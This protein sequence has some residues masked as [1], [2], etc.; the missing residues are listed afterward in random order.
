MHSLP[1]HFCCSSRFAR[2][3]KVENF[4]AKDISHP[5][6]ERTLILLSA[7][8]NFV[9]F[10]EQFCNPFVKDLRDR[11]DAMIIERDQVSR[12]LA[13][14]QQK[15]EATKW[16]FSS[17]LRPIS[18]HFDLRTKI[19]EDEPR[20]EQLRRENS[21][22]RARMF[23]TKEFQTA[24]VQEVE[25]LKAEKS[26][27]IKR[28]ASLRNNDTFFPYKRM[29]AMLTQEVLNGEITSISDAVTRSR[30]RIVQSPERIKRTISTM[31]S[32]AIEDKKIVTL[33]ETKARDLQAKINA[34]LNIEKACHFHF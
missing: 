21:A 17:R 6:R 24:A 33:H 27:L 14:V 29:T 31:S 12:E 23:A 20:C 8:I 19:A 32:T 16:A 25:K 18:S 5:E 15:I 13:E 26:A 11:S 1:T 3:A 28:K 2:A 22:L 30:S 10:T 7:F 34:L 4:N 9:K